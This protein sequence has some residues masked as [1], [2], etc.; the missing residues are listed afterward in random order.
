LYVTEA[1]SFFRRSPSISDFFFALALREI[2]HL[3]VLGPPGVGG[4]SI[5]TR[6]AQQ[7][8]YDPPLGY[9]PR[10]PDWTRCRVMV[11]GED[12][13]FIPIRVPSHDEMIMMNPCSGYALVYS[14]NDSDSLLQLQRYY[15]MILAKHA[16]KPPGKPLPPLVL[17]ANKLDLATVD[18]SQRQ[19]AHEE[20]QRLAGQYGAAFFEVSAKTG[21]SVAE[22]FAALIR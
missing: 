8:F 11:D 14:V 15:D 20:G 10:M 4:E 17:I 12:N 13:A 22:P 6:I 1:E 3:L 5:I 18:P 9:D 19:V 7:H 16:E 2:P 21:E